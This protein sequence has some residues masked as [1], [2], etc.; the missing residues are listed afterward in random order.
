MSRP[1][2]MDADENGLPIRAERWQCIN[3][4]NAEAAPEGKI[5]PYWLT[6]DEDD[7]DSEALCPECLDKEVEFS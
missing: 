2:V 7:L 5:P 4:P 6:A 3:C 1:L